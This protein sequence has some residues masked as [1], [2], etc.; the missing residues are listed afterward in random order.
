MSHY[1]KVGDRVSLAFGFYDQNA[2]GTYA[3]TRLLP[4][5]ANGEHQYRVKGAD[6]RERV[7]GEGQIIVPGRSA[8]PSRPRS[9]HNPITNMLNQLPARK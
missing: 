4:T 7:I 6:D 2:T 3:V 5:R 8:S 9:A 1:F